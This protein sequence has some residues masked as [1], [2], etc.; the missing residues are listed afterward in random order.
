M[1]RSL[2]IIYVDCAPPRDETMAFMEPTYDNNF[3]NL[4]KKIKDCFAVMPIDKA[5]TKVEYLIA[6][7]FVARHPP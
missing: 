5:I 1:A 6:L 4:V 7:E 2:F 3:S